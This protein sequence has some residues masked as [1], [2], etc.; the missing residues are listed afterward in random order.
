MRTRMP[1]PTLP[2]KV[3]E[4][5]E[6]ELGPEETPKRFKPRTPW[7]RTCCAPCRNRL[8]YLEVRRD[9]LAAELAARGGPKRRGRRPKVADERQGASPPP[10]PP[11]RKP[12]ESSDGMPF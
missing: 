10:I 1:F 2:E 9:K 8:N 11:G 12:E 4:N 6:C 5:P 7:Q 3:C